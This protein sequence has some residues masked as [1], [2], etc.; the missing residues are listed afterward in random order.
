MQAACE[1]MV[2]AA[3][4][5]NPAAHL[6]MCFL[7]QLALL[8]NNSL[9]RFSTSSSRHTE[10]RGGDFGGNR[11]GHCASGNETLDA[12]EVVNCWMCRAR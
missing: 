1:L 9:V 8:S 5:G 10:Y 11:C 3:E 12:C 7:W 6:L 4:V 2:S